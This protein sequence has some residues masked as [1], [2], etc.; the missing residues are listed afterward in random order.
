TVPPTA[1]PELDPAVR[2]AFVEVAE[3]RFGLR[4]TEQQA[5]QLAALASALAARVGATDPLA[6]ARSLAAGH[7][8]ELL[9]EIA[10]TLTIHETHFFRVGP[11]I[12]ALRRTILPDLLRARAATRRLRLWSAGCSTGEEPYTLAM[13]LAS[14]FPAADG[15]SVEILASDLSTRVLAA[16]RDGV[17]PVERSNDIPEPLRKAYMLRGV[18]SEEGRMRAHSS[19]QSMITFRRINLN[20]DDYGI[21]TRFDLLFCRN[22]LIYF[23]RESKERVINRLV[24]H[25]SGSGLLFLGHSESLAATSFGMEHAGPTVYRRTG[26]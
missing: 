21:N 22:V 16:A 23:N 12:E 18:R 1:P 13:V 4:P 14:H 11:Q 9:D 7:H 8:P 15:W 5:D 2:A 10:A 20:D 24:R 19:L 6:L 26:S 3:R 25:L 17:W